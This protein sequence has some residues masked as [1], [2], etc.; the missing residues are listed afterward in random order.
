MKKPTHFIE[1]YRDEVIH[2]QSWIPLDIR[3]LSAQIKK[4]I[5]TGFK[6]IAIFK[7]YEKK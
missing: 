1:V 6:T 4:S 7:I 2:S 5:K 3:F